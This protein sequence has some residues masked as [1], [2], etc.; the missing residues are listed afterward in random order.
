MTRLSH[1]E[2]ESGPQIF[3]CRC[4]SSFCSLGHGGGLIVDLAT[5]KIHQQ[6]QQQQ[7]QLSA[8]H[9]RGVKPSSN[10][11]EA[12]CHCMKCRHIND[13]RPMKQKTWYTHSRNQKNADAR[14]AIQFIND[15]EQREDALNRLNITLPKAKSKKEKEINQANL[16]KSVLKLDNKRLHYRYENERLRGEQ[17][18]NVAQLDYVD[19]IITETEL[20]REQEE[21]VNEAH[22]RELYSQIDPVHDDRLDVEYDSL[23]LQPP[24]RNTFQ[25]SNYQ[26]L[27]DGCKEVLTKKTHAALMVAFQVR[28]HLTNVAMNDFLKLMKLYMPQNVNAEMVLDDHSKNRTRVDKICG[29]HEQRITVCPDDCFAV[30]G[31]NAKVE[32]RARANGDLVKYVGKVVQLEYDESVPFHRRL[33]ITCPKCGLEL[34]KMVKRKQRLDARPKKVI[35]YFPIKD[36]IRKLYG[37]RAKAEQLGYALDRIQERRKYRAV[38]KRYPRRQDCV[39]DE[40]AEKWH[41]ANENIN[42]VHDIQD[43]RGWE[44]EI[45]D[46]NFISD[47]NSLNLVISIC[48]DGINAFSQNTQ[49]SLWPLI[50][51]IN[52]YHPSIRNRETSIFLSS[53]SDGQRK[54][55]NLDPYLGLLLDELDQINDPDG[56]PNSEHQI[57]VTDLLR[58]PHG[59][60]KRVFIKLLLVIGDYKGQGEL[61]NHKTNGYYCCTKCTIEG[62]GFRS[63]KR[64]SRK[65]TRQ[66]RI[67]STT[68]NKKR[69]RDEMKSQLN[70]E[71]EVDVDEEADVEEKVDVTET[72]E[73]QSQDAGFEKR[74][75]TIEVYADFHLFVDPNP[76]RWPTIIL[77]N[78]EWHRD[79]TVNSRMGKKGKCRLD[80]LEYYDPLYQTPPEMMHISGT[81]IKRFC[82]LIFPVSYSRP[83][84][85]DCI[86]ITLTSD[87]LKNVRHRLRELKLPPK[88]INKSKLDSAFKLSKSNC[89]DANANMI[90]LAGFTHS[91]FHHLCGPLLKYILIDC[92]NRPD[93]LFSEMKKE[94]FNFFD[95]L[96]SLMSYVISSNPDELDLLHQKVIM[97]LSSLYHFLPKSTFTI[98]FHQLVHVVQAL[99][100]WG[101]AKGYWMYPFERFFGQLTRK[102]S[103]RKDPEQSIINS[104]RLYVAVDLIKDEYNN[105]VMSDFM[106]KPVQYNEYHYNSWHIEHHTNPLRH[107]IDLANW[108]IKGLQRAVHH[109]KLSGRKELPLNH[110]YAQLCYYYR[111]Y[112]YPVYGKLHT[113]FVNQKRHD[114]NLNYEQ[115]MHYQQELGCLSAEEQ[116]FMTPPTTRAYAYKTAVVRGQEY[117][118]ADM[119]KEKSVSSYIHSAYNNTGNHVDVKLFTGQI[120]LFIKHTFGGETHDL[121]YVD[122]FYHNTQDFHLDANLQ[123][124]NL[125]VRKQMDHFMPISQITGHVAVGPKPNS[126]DH[127]I[128]PMY[129]KELEQYTKE[130][131]RMFNE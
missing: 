5:Y 73:E 94:L 37:I 129:S 130:N 95:V 20:R 116:Q 22:E 124:T 35:R 126:N 14:D 87:E 91:D 56:D 98:Q 119:D 76:K 42:F 12:V 72:K 96:K 108:R 32:K 33:L 11:T 88:I 93:K 74:G 40:E 106:Q 99:K 15:L 49:H 41:V 111:E 4:I 70:D 63:I 122:W 29:L 69:K 67:Q 13:N 51:I 10:F 79:I 48:A 6:R 60:P 7:D 9:I 131:I 52:N 65:T 34:Y 120:M 90:V 110:F 78:K 80:E 19:A 113:A 114:K 28:H 25:D 101:P 66:V 36:Y 121:A 97:S 23:T 53:L 17:L 127:Y 64:N 71:E 8:A 75:G 77:K 58:D 16:I 54:P 125:S 123:F 31:N 27:Y 117:Q 118:T 128:I 105:S 62:E 43:S 61:L 26:P 89:P 45:V 3:L 112:A 18:D 104:Q 2:E 102:R 107:A 50:V 103:S 47:T 82:E 83:M 81:I 1:Q 39:T 68:T 92:W 115:F 30:V 38:L 109:S 44:K 24:A 59:R 86:H 84:T 85:K 21:Q 57:W 100:R 55:K 46:S